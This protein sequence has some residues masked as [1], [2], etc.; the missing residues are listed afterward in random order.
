MNAQPVPTPHTN[1]PRSG[2]DVRAEFLRRGL[3]I[4]AWARSRGYSAQLVYQV[5][6]GRRGCVRGQCHEIAVRLGMKEGIIGSTAE[7]EA[8]NP[9][10]SAPRGEEEIAR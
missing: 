8:M 6:A 5:L 4:S 10:P 3:S 2:A 9:V 1:A 7:I